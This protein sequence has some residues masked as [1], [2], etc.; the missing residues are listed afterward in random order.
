MDLSSLEIF[1][2]V[3]EEASVTRAAKRLS[4]APSN[5]TTRIQALEGQ[6][7]AV[8]FSRDGKR[9]TLTPEGQLFLSYAK[10]LTALAEEARL[11]LKSARPQ[12]ILRLGT[13]ESTAASRL[14]P[15]LARF[16]DENPDISL[17][18]TLGAT[19]ELTKAVI[20][21]ELDCALIATPQG[22]PGWLSSAG[23]DADDLHRARVCEEDLL[24][25]LPPHHASVAAP[26]DIRL[27][28]LAA[29][30]PGCTYRQIAERWIRAGASLPT[31]EMTSYH[32]I[33]AQVVAGNAVGV[34]PRSVLDMLPWRAEV[35]IH[36]LGPVDT[37]LISRRERR[38][39]PLQ[40]FEQIMLMSANPPATLQ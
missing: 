16:N 33:L 7:H 27:P 25:V 24:L 2:V 19:R 18:L 36:R 40:V 31:V 22:E 4:R 26:Q 5:V 1:L 9:M 30:E 21:G 15:V 17:K 8:L 10:R 34:M 39:K 28:A 13:M 14:P 23:V 38:S 20:S 6:M 37:L 32:A 35:T 11:A 3:A 29:L 12:P